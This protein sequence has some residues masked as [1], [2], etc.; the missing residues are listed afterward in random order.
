MTGNTI[1]PVDRQGRKYLTREERERFL[2]AATRESKP[3]HRTFALVAA[4]S[5]AR[6]S[7]VLAPRPAD[8][9]LTAGA[10]CSDCRH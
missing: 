10:S 1:F 8:I 5:G 2:A 9:D 6:I 7:E 3:E 4:H